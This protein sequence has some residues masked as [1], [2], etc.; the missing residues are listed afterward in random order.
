MQ[1]A[2]QFSQFIAH[3]L[4]SID[5]LQVIQMDPNIKETFKF[6]LVKFYFISHLFLS[7]LYLYSGCR[8]KKNTCGFAEITTWIAA[9]K[10]TRRPE[11]ERAE[12]TERINN[13][14]I[15]VH[16]SGSDDGSNIRLNCLQQE[17]TSIDDKRKKNVRTGL[18]INIRLLNHTNHKSVSV[19]PVILLSLWGWWSKSSS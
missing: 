15:M 11:M 9:T 17:H 8:K 14:A 10:N 13:Q 4:K 6:S 3:H 19:F 7:G 5:R 1:S 12:Q 16:E 18:R 2:I